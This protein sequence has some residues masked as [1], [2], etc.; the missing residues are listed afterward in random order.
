MSMAK[1]F[2]T[3]VGETLNKSFNTGKDYFIEVW[4]RCYQ[5]EILSYDD[6]ELMVE[7][8]S[9]DKVP[10]G[11][12]AGGSEKYFGEFETHILN[13]TKADILDSLIMNADPSFFKKY[14]NLK[15]G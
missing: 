3:K 5:V 8:K 15:V 2:E 13:R 10:S 6:G 9:Y 11:V 12:K 1:Y 7:I 4:E 14:S